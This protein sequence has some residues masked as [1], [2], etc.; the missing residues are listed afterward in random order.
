MPKS[1]IKPDG[2]LVGEAVVI[3]EYFGQKEGQ[4][5]TDFMRELRALD[6]ASKTELAI[7]AAEKLGYSVAG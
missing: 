4:N 3:K 7:G 6:E 5:A 2:S 1:F